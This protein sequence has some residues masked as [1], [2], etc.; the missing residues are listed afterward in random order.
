MMTVVL[1]TACGDDDDGLGARR[2]AASTVSSS[3]A[4]GA[5]AGQGGGGQ[6]GAPACDPWAD[7]DCCVTSSFCAEG[8][9]GP[10]V[11]DVQLCGGACEGRANPVP[12]APCGSMGTCD[13]KT[14]VEPEPMGGTG[15]TGG[16]G[17]GQ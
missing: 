15:G 13:E 4:G 14:C 12:D 3:S 7:E 6:G 2:P 17:G 1:L 8:S 5:D 16:V 10:C 9:L 11:V